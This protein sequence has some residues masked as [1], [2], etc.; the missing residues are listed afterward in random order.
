MTV[1]VFADIACP[2]CYIG[3]G[4][5]AEALAE[6]RSES[7]EREVTWRWRPF[8]LQ[9]EFIYRLAFAGVCDLR[10]LHRWE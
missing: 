8:Q 3:E 4:R 10:R 7:P 1:D 6:V 5:F 2:F 9:P